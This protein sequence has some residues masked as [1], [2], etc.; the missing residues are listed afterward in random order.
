M[1]RIVLPYPPSGAK[2]GVVFHDDAKEAA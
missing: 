1:I 2:H